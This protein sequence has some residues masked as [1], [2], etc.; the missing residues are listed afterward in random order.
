MITCRIEKQLKIKKME[1]LFK[2]KNGG[3]I[4]IYKLIDGDVN[5]YMEDQNRMSESLNVNLKIAGNVE[6]F[7]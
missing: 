5:S 2:R 4:Q 3:I 7:T 6:F 1:E